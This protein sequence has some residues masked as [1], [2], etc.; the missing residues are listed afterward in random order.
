MPCS[1]AP[2]K[3]TAPTPATAAASATLAGGLRSCGAIAGE[4]VVLLMHNSIDQLVTWFA[5]ARLGA[6]H[7]PLNTALIG[8][9]LAHALPGHRGPAGRRRCRLAA[10]AGADPED[11]PCWK[12]SS[13]AAVAA[14]PC[15]QPGRRH[16]LRHLWRLDPTVVPVDVDDL[17]AATVLFTSGTT[18]VS[19]GCVLSHRYLVRQAELHVANLG[20]TGM[21]C[22]TRRSRSSIS[23][24]R[25]SPWSPR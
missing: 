14:G 18:G 11:C 8:A 5:L 1:C 21:T 19:K 13:S 24:P 23:T 12:G 15:R 17:A 3:A 20:L 4:P 6:V 7:V 10:R 22:C 25:R 9:S 16:R 2:P